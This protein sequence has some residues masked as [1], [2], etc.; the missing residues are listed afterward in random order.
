MGGTSAAFGNMTVA[1]A[2]AMGTVIA[3]GDLFL[4]E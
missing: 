4:E 3:C 1:S 2:T